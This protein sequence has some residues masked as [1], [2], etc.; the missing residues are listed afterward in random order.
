MKTSLLTG[1][2]TLLIFV[3]ASAAD[4]INILTPAEK[5][6]G[7]RLLFDGKD[8]SQFRGFKKDA[9]PAEGWAVEDGCL[10]KVANVKAGDIITKDKFT[11]FEFS[12]EWKLGPG[13]NNGIKYFILEERGAVGHEYQMIDDAIVKKDAL[14]SAASFYL[15]VAPKKD[16]PLK[17]P[18][19]WNHS[20]VMVKGNHVEHW[21]NGEKVLEYECG[22][23]PIL[24]QVQLTKFKNVK[25]FGKK[26]TGHIL[27]T[28]HKDECWYRNLKVRELKASVQ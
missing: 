14:S 3:T 28:D 7:W 27:L 21:L 23:E 24:Q 25:D 19:E 4:Q 20:R 9:F 17:P 16:K 11:D 26:V 12:W 18:G 5:K 22:S 10:K 15:V 8:T 13:G 2:L 1:L 6:A